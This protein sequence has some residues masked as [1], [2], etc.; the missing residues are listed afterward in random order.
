MIDLVTQGVPR[1][2]LLAASGVAGTGLGVGYFQMVRLS[3]RLLVEGGG[4]PLAVGLTVGR[5]AGLGLCL[6]GASSQGAGPL[7]MMA[8]GLMIGRRIALRG[9]GES[10]P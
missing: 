4:A 6:L 2:V 10:L 5:M 3:A 1:L 7:L 9:N 8:G